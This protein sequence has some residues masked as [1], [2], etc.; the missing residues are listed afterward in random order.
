MS[1]V[2]T[3]GPLMVGRRSKVLEDPVRVEIIR[4]RRRLSPPNKKLKI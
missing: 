4:L 2:T 1:L 3:T